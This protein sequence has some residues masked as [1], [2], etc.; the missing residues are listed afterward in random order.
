ML[1]FNKYLPVAVTG[2]KLKE[3][4]KYI[5]NV[6]STKSLFIERKYGEHV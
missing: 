1:T 5:R 3:E 6:L 2:S 4:E